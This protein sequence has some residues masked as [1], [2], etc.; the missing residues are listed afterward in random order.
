MGTLERSE[1]VRL[2]RVLEVEQKE[3]CDAAAGEESGT[4]RVSDDIEQGSSVGARTEG[5]G[6]TELLEQH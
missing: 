4:E 3:I 1:L 5:D 6:L 2:H